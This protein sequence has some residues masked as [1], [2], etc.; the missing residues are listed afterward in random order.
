MYM[1][2]PH[3][4]VSIV[5]PLLPEYPMQLPIKYCAIT[6]KQAGTLGKSSDTVCLKCQCLT[7][8]HLFTKIVQLLT[9]AQ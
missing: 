8:R 9:Y 4:L 1:L 5:C 3:I 6:K 2:M 7:K